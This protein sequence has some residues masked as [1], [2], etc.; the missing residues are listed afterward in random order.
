MSSELSPTF[1]AACGIVAGIA[2][3]FLLV[4]YRLHFHPLSSYPG[5]VVAR[6]SDL[7]GAF[8]AYST[9]LHLRTLKDHDDYGT[10]IRHGPNKL[11]FNSARALR[12]IYKNEQILKS[13]AYLVSQTA[14][15]VFNLFNARDPQLHHEKRKLA[16]R[17]LTKKSIEAFEPVMMH[18][19]DVFIHQIASHCDDT[20]VRPVNMTPQTKHLSIDIMGHLLFNY[21]LNLQ[22]E[23]THR[24]MS[25]SRASFFFNVATQVSSLVDLRV[26]TLQ[27]LWSMMSRKRYVHT[28]ENV[29]R[30]CL[31]QGQ[32]VKHKLLFL[33]A[34]S[35]V[36]GDDT[37][38]I[39]DVRTEALWFMLAGSDTTSTLLSALSFY[40]ARNRRCYQRLCKEIRT[41]F[42]Q[43]SEI[44][45]G[46]RL[47]SC[48]YLRA[49]L[50]ETLRMTPPL[51]G[52]L[53]REGISQSSIK[54]LIVDGHVIPK[55]VQVGV[56]TYAILHNEEYFSEP[57]TFKPERWLEGAGPGEANREAFAPFS[58]GAHGCLGKSMAYLE[59]SLTT[60]KI[61]W[62]FDFDE[63][64]GMLAVPGKKGAKQQARNSEFPIRD[65]F[66]AVHDGPYLN[67]RRVGS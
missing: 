29:I 60:A 41:T 23:S 13:R 49:C 54:P 37:D 48:A 18:Q 47:A 62:H 50:D 61:I 21:P 25:Y 10:V 33:S 27:F 15:G 1:I 28:L 42:N 30:N 66:A 64:P 5:P 58:L 36:S 2:Y 6:L 44:R 56:N 14:P 40:L 24:H 45:S 20:N 9:S 39:N 35:A 11:V 65:S 52:T 57:F 46:A 7:F 38:W 43:D 26:W 12:D 4:L 31:S 59:A 19:I 51:P 3:L 67:F 63:A 22:T 8:Y 34:K 17:F 32:Q 53:W 16:G 55:G